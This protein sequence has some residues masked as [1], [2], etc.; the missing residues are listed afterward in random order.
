MNLTEPERS[1]QVANANDL[2]SIP[3]RSP[4]SRTEAGACSL[5][6]FIRR[7]RR[8]P[9]LAEIK[10]ILAEAMGHA[11][12]LSVVEGEGLVRALSSYLALE[13]QDHRVFGELQATIE[14]VFHHYPNSFNS[15]P[16]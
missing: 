6:D 12:S 4:M 1:L 3:T 11:R 14:T 7:N 16:S 2:P 8:E 9:S 15:S 10:T 13:A 5:V